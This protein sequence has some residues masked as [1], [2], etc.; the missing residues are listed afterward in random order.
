MNLLSRPPYA[1]DSKTRR[2]SVAT[3]VLFQDANLTINPGNRVA[4]V[5]PNGAGKTTLFRMILGEGHPD[6]GGSERDEWST[7]GFSPRERAGG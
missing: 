1:D 3:K 6:S 4:P 2:K 7:T 5:G